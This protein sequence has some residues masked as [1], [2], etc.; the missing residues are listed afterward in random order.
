[1]RQFSACIEWLFARE[2]EDFGER[3]RLAH[4]AGLSAVEFW[5]WTNK[6]LDAIASAVAE[7]GIAVAGL[8]AEPMIALTRP[9]NKEVWLEGLRASLKVAQRLGAPV[10]I[11]QAGD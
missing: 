4:R 11:A 6:D 1:M 10:L 9:A 8:V 7:T 3:I 5:R 2:G